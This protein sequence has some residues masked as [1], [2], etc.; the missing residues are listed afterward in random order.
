MIDGEISVDSDDEVER[1]QVTNPRTAFG[2]LSPLHYVFVVSDGRTKENV[3]LS[4]LE[5]AQFM[6][7]LGCNTAY[8]LDGG[9]SS[10]M[11]FNGEVLNHPTTFGDAIAERKISDIVYIS[12]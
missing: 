2:V 12:K 8:N 11:W 4:L 10:T 7:E 3:G 1:A 9:G 6:K 5:L